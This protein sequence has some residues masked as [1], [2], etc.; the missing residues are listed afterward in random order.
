ML[1]ATGL[2]VCY[3]LLFKGFVNG[4]DSSFH[5][6]WAQQFLNSLR[7]GLLYPQWVS[8]ANLGC[9]N[10]TFI[11]YPPFTLFSYA[12]I[13]LITDDMLTILNISV[14]IGMICSGLAMYFFGRMYME[15]PAAFFAAVLY[16][17]LPYHLIDL[18][19]RS[20]LAEFWA[21][22][23]IPAVCYFTVKVE[24]SRGHFMWLSLSYAGLLLTHLPSALLFTPFLLLF[25]IVVLAKESNLKSLL[26]RL[27]ALFLGLGLS[28][29]Y[30][31]PALAERGNVNFK[32][33][34]A[35]RWFRIGSNFLF[36]HS[37]ADTTFNRKISIIAVTTC[38]LS[39]CALIFWVIQRK[40][41]R[42]PSRLP[43]LF[44][45]AAGILTFVLMLPVS[46]I[47]W[48]TLPVLTYVQFPWRLLTTSTFFASLSAGMLGE[49]A[50]VPASRTGRRTGAIAALAVSAVVALN[51]YISWRTVAEAKIFPFERAALLR[52]EGLNMRAD[53]A[54]RETLRNFNFFLTGNLWLMDV[55]EYRP[56]WSVQK[57]VEDM[58]P[59]GGEDPVKTLA[60]YLANV[61]EKAGESPLKG[62]WGEEGL[63]Y[64]RHGPYILFPRPEILRSIYKTEMA[65]AIPY[66]M[67]EE[68]VVFSRG[69]GEAQIAKWEAEHRVMRVKTDGPAQI[70]VKTF[71][72][73]RWKAMMDGGEITIS[74]A[75]LTG[76]IV[77]DIPAGTHTFEMR[78][79]SGLPRSVGII[80]AFISL[81]LV[82]FLSLKS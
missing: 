21:F 70:M 43:E 8:D 19:T 78:F 18:F 12:A 52:T 82:V 50:L 37:L 16:M 56:L 17:A 30:L 32:V 44:F 46:E 80:I 75:P 47:L 64:E 4:D 36:S 53:S 23:W 1:C 29:F 9:G 3:P 5:M 27:A 69:S 72:Y 62:L 7:S 81:I 73:P 38:L 42:S 59:P 58:S 24:E 48:D 60:E 41:Q 20:A 54:Y 13:S 25:S 10:A 77:A 45:A 79:A 71:Y 11:F 40:G 61:S 35:D 26:R 68:N 39:A 67:L 33:L 2:A 57:V 15:R 22:A 34:T 28:S 74:P 63:S 6:L 66:E 65:A 51:G 14:L 76:L 55:P 31:V 49:R